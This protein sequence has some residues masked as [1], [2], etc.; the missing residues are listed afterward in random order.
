MFT[1]YVRGGVVDNAKNSVL[2]I[3]SGTIAEINK[4]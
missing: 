1:M 3:D 4:I 2:T